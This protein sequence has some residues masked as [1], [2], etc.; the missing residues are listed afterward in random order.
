MMLTICRFS[1]Y[2][3]PNLPSKLVRL[4]FPDYELRSKIN[5]NYI[6]TWWTT[7]DLESLE[8]LK[9]YRPSRGQKKTSMAGIDTSLC[10]PTRRK[11]SD[12]DIHYGSDNTSNSIGSLS[13]SPA[14]E[15]PCRSRNDTHSSYISST[16]QSECKEARTHM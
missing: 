1:P 14:I 9:F 3:M 6:T 8:I 10:R 15:I 12:P 5:L 2:P 7:V 16:L 11:L 4:T 13:K